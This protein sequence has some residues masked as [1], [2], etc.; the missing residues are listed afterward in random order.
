MHDTIRNKINISFKID[1][2]KCIL[3]YQPT[4]DIELQLT[5]LFKQI[6]KIKKLITAQMKNG[7][8]ESILSK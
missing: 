4:F 2:N 8:F 6:L 5:H 1:K 7:S 3:T